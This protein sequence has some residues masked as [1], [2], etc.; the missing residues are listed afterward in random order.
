MI[1]YPPY[2]FFDPVTEPITLSS[3]SFV[4]EGI[5]RD[6]NDYW[7]N[8]VGKHW[9]S[10]EAHWNKIYEFITEWSKT[11]RDLITEEFGSGIDEPR[12]KCII[13][14]K[15]EYENFNMNHILQ[16]LEGLGKLANMMHCAER[17]VLIGNHVL[18]RRDDYPLESS[19]VSALE[20]IVWMV[21]TFVQD[22]RFTDLVTRL[23]QLPSP[24]LKTQGEE[25]TG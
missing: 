11:Y 6:F 7:N 20:Q 13:Q 2:W 15:Q 5:D 14:G 17:D 23:N 16:L 25:N 1:K 12:V 19:Y 9:G 22:G 10:K 4:F 24:K 8:D 21:G 18:R 3:H